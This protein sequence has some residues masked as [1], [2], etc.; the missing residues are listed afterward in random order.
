MTPR[1]IRTVRTGSAERFVLQNSDGADCGALDLH[2]LSNGSVAGTLFILEG[3]GI[4]ESEVPSLLN[5]IDED[6]L[7]DVSFSA[8]TLSFT[9]VIGRIAGNFVSDKPTRVQ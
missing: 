2:H 1:F 5:R 4:S 7:P 9:V 8:E 6:L 3:T